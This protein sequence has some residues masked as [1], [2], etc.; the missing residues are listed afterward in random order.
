MDDEGS[1]QGPE[2]RDDAVHAPLFA[3]GRGPGKLPVVSVGSA[4]GHPRAKNL[5]NRELLTDFRWCRNAATTLTSF[6][7]DLQEALIERNIALLHAPIPMTSVHSYAWAPHR[8][9]NPPAPMCP[10][11]SPTAP[12]VGE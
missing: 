8:L 9:E 6:F 12:G 7:I 3:S 11:I 4:H 2:A 5:E 10:E 1:R